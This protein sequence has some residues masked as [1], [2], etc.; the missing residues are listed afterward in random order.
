MGLNVGTNYLSSKAYEDVRLTCP[1]ADVESYEYSLIG[2][3]TLA[4][5]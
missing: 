1:A 2:S 4:R 3:G 5:V